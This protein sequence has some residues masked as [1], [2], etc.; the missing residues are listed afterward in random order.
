MKKSIIIGLTLGIVFALAGCSSV[1]TITSTTTSLSQ[2]P[3]TILQGPMK[4]G[5][6][7]NPINFDMKMTITSGS[8]TV[9]VTNPSQEIVYPKTTFSSGT[10]TVSQKF[11]P[12]SGGG[13]WNYNVVTSQNASGDMTISLKQNQ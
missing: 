11:Q 12:I 8:A 13:V 1:N 7:K 2:V 9:W 4:Q 5:S 3:A 6:S 10:S